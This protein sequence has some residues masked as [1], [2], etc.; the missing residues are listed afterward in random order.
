M[1]LVCSYS[2]TT[3]NIYCTLPGTTNT[4]GNNDSFPLNSIQLVSPSHQCPGNRLHNTEGRKLA[5][6]IPLSIKDGGIYYSEPC[7]VNGI[8]TATNTVTKTIKGINANG[9]TNSSGG[10]GGGGGDN[11]STSGSNSNTSG[12][13]SGGGISGGY[14]TNPAL[15]L[16]PLTARALCAFGSGSQVNRF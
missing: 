3:L 11:S 8:N 1:Y 7:T 12:S 2:I 9:N 13:T 15:C 16:N 5:P 10:G 6:S 14:S 4:G